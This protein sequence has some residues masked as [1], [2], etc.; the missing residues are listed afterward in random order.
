MLLGRSH[1]RKQEAETGGNDQKHGRRDKSGRE[2]EPNLEANACPI[3]LKMLRLGIA[4]SRRHR[5]PD[6]ECERD[7]SNDDHRIEAQQ[8]EEHAPFAGADDEVRRRPFVVPAHRLARERNGDHGAEKRRHG[9]ESQQIEKRVF[10]QEVR[11]RRN[12][13][14]HRGAQAL[15]EK[16]CRHRIE[17]RGQPTQSE[18]LEQPSKQK[19]I[20]T[21][22]S[23]PD[24]NLRHNTPAALSATFPDQ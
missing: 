17:Q 24:G 6:R 10:A 22:N 8:R 13:A 4:R 9:D 16:G 20:G 11:I 21:R 23:V 12:R 3:E 7:R 15:D 2:I 1:G 18:N 5:D 19:A 14:L